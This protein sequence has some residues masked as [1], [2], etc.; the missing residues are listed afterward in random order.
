MTD[1]A[2]CGACTSVCPVYNATGLESMTARGKIHLLERLSTKKISPAFAEILSKCL[3]CGACEAVCSRGIDLVTRFTEARQELPLLVGEHPIIAQLAKIT[4]GS[5]S[6]LNAF[7]EVGTTL[8]RLLP[9][10]SGLRIRLGLSAEPDQPVSSPQEHPQPAAPTQ[11]TVNYFSGC[12]ARYPQPEIA[13]ATNL[14]VRHSGGALQAPDDQTCCGQAA[15]GSGNIK[16]AIN[17]A[18]QNINAF[19]DNDLPIVT[20]CASCYSHLASYPHLLRD[21]PEWGAKARCF[22][23]RLREFSSY[24]ADRSAARQ[25]PKNS[26]TVFYHDPCHL[27]FRHR[28]TKPPRILLKNSGFTVIEPTNGPQCCGMGG[29]FH[30]NHPELSEKIRHRLL[31]N[32]DQFAVDFVVTTC[33]GCLLQL[34]SGL[35]KSPQQPVAVRHLAV[36]LAEM[37]KT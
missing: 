1:C 26:K 16:A 6:L 25:T 4:L 5:P 28:I 7:A 19:A 21:D 34:R 29:L 33:T 10:N 20:S 35:S 23:D 37:L 15:Y 27:R 18:K 13:Q 9:K 30:L 24:F 36:L 14:L 8:D 32:H 17:L 12:L 31:E 11:P 3:L 2:K 22:S